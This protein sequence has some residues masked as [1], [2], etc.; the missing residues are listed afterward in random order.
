MTGKPPLWGGVLCKSDYVIALANLTNLE[1]ITVRCIQ[2]AFHLLDCQ[3]LHY[4]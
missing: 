3:Y 2:P 1:H 4:L